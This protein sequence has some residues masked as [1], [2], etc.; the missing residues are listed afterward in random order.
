MFIF[1]Q[2]TCFLS[3][4]RIQIS[5]LKALLATSKNASSPCPGTTR[6]SL[7]WTFKKWKRHLT[8][9]P[10]SVALAANVMTSLMRLNR[11]FGAGITCSVAS[12]MSRFLSSKFIKRMHLINSLP[13]TSKDTRS[14]A[15]YILHCAR[16]LV[17]TNCKTYRCMQRPVEFH[18]N[19]FVIRILCN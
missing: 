7:Y 15:P 1:P 18:T 11:S 3:L 12:L 16:K 10:I 17:Y 13:G 2:P 5:V 14:S 8:H 4:L 6:F 9:I 19:L